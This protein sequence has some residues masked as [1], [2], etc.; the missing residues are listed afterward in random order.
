L[1]GHGQGALQVAFANDGA[2]LAAASTSG[3][4]KIWALDTLA[5]RH[6]L[7]ATVRGQIAVAFAPDGRRLATGGNDH[8]VHLWDAVSGAHLLRVPFAEAIW[9]LAWSRDGHRLLVIPLDRTIR[10][11]AASPAAASGR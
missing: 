11:L 3:A 1:A 10:V 6:E 7:S 9:D 2:W 8:N 4:I 5:L